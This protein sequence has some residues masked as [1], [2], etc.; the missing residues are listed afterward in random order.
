[1]IYRALASSSSIVNPSPVWGGPG[2]FTNP[3]N[4]CDENG[5]VDGTATTFATGTIDGISIVVASMQIGPSAVVAQGR[6]LGILLDY[7]VVTL[8]GNAF[9]AVGFDAPQYNIS[10]TV[11]TTVGRAQKTVLWRSAANPD[12]A[13]LSTASAFPISLIAEW[14][15]GGAMSVKVYEMVF[16]YDLRGDVTIIDG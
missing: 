4:V 1:M 16:L 8:S 2:T 11:A 10:Y 15:G 14:G 12:A 6:W 9:F 13:S 5:K 7:E 3:T